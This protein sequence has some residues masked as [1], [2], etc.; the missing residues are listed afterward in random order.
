VRDSAEVLYQA[1]K[2]MAGLVLRAIIQS[3][4]TGA[5]FADVANK[6]IEIAKADG[7]QDCAQFVQKHF[8]FREVLGAKAFAPHVD[9]SNF[10]M[11]PSRRCSCGTMQHPQYRPKQPHLNGKDGKQD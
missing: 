1:G 9:L 7:E 5:T 6:M 2:Y 10:G 3:P 11:Y 4:D 8:E